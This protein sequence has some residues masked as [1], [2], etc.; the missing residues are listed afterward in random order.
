MPLIMPECSF[1]LEG[2][3]SA[4]DAL[5][6]VKRATGSL[7]YKGGRFV[8]YLDKW[9]RAIENEDA[10]ALRPD[11][12]RIVF[13][14]AGLA[15]AYEQTAWFLAISYLGED[16]AVKEFR[17]HPYKSASGE[18][19]DRVWK[20]TVDL[21]QRFVAITNPSL[22]LATGRP[23][24]DED[25]D[26]LVS[27]NELSPG[28]LPPFLTPWNYIGPDRLNEDRRQFLRR[29]P[30]A[31][32][33]PLGDGWLLRVTLGLTEKPPAELLRELRHAPDNHPVGYRYPK[34]R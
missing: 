31:Q 9:A 19:L 13:N 4:L 20:T 26:Y 30:A 10:G 12:F 23:E 7:D 29:L 27:A 32:S 3:M 5:R 15:A 2:E 11:G 34:G 25:T 22:A 1:Y 17:I 8:P 16:P 24:Q 6:L 21:M 14:H 33:E 18:E 28:S